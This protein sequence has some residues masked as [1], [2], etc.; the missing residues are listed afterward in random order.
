MRR[1]PYDNYNPRDFIIRDWL[2]L[3][4]TI[5]ANERTFLAYG[6]TTLTLVIAGLSFVKFFGHVAYS[7]IGY[8][9]IAAGMVIFLFG[10]KRFL[11][12]KKHYK[13]LSILEDIRYPT[14]LQKEM[15]IAPDQIN[16]I[17]AEHDGSDSKSRQST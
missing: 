10:L 2:A 9:F 16:Q 15:Q 3:D 8:A 7:I 6:R 5:L 17:L 14:Q 1:L 13:A 12:T 4:R 11:K